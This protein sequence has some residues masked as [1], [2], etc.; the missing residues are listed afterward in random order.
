[1]G[2]SLRT[3][4]KELPL[5]RSCCG[6]T[7]SFVIEA[8]LRPTQLEVGRSCELVVTLANTD[9]GVCSDIVFKLSIP[10][11]LVLLRGSALV[12]V[13]RLDRGESIACVLHV[14]AKQVGEFVLSSQNFSYRDRFGT[15]Q[16]VMTFRTMIAAVRTAPA[17]EAPQ[18][19]LM[20][21]LQATPL[22][23]GEWVPLKGSV[24]N[25]G[26]IAISELA[27]RAIGPLI[28][29]PLKPWNDVGA[30]LPGESQTFAIYCRAR[31]VGESV[32]VYI[33][34]K[35]KDAA[36]RN[37][38]RQC[39]TPIDVVLPRASSPES[40]RHSRTITI[41]FLSADPT[42]AN[43]LRTGQE[44]RDIEDEL[45]LAKM[46]DK[47]QLDARFSIRPSDISR[48]LLDLRPQIVHFSGHGTR[49]GA[50]C[51]EDETGAVQPVSPGAL[52]DL[53]GIGIVADSVRCVVLNACYSAAQAE[54]ISRH[55]EYVIGMDSTV[56]DKAAIAFAVG[57]YQALGAG[58][59]IET[60]FQLGCAQIRLWE[61]PDYLTPVLKKRS[62]AKD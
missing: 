34:L 43:P 7:D 29:D 46:R 28:C 49:D 50:L 53:F 17:A 48:V 11:Q 23:L 20:V 59:S 19:S 24:E 60:A 13:A 61:F 8:T 5:A 35:Y 21:T 36:G 54:A 3:V 44:L 22:P 45:K 27:L 1:V 57:F 31:E 42:G 14:R 12:R 30:L 32:P 56:G 10:P 39:F 33:D 16:R 37:A 26:S 25:T 55:I 15:S 9:V 38:Q 51:L 47:L 6:R 58:C 2:L 41:V 18:S 40:R 52:Q 4:Q 62:G